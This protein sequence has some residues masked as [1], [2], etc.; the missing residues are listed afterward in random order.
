MK[1]MNW[2]AEQAMTA[3]GIAESD[4]ASYLEKIGNSWS[5][6]FADNK[7]ADQMK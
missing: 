1:N 6:A 5:S 2:T 4:R 3:L 7:T